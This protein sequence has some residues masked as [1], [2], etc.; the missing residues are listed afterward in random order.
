MATLEHKGTRVQRITEAHI[1]KRHEGDVPHSPSRNVR[2]AR[3]KPSVLDDVVTLDHPCDVTVP[4]A[5]KRKSVV[6]RA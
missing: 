2:H 3:P 1:R 6:V 4:F 5:R